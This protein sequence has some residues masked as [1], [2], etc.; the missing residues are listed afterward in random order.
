MSSS[1]QLQTANNNNDEAGVKQQLDSRQQNGNN[2]TNGAAKGNGICPIKS[3]AS[4]DWPREHPRVL[5]PELCNQFYQLGWVS[6]TGGGLSIKQGGVIHCAPSG[7]QKERLRPEDMF[8]LN[9]NYEVIE[10]PRDPK[11][12]ISECLPLFRM[13]FDKR[14][15]GCCIHSH[16]IYANL[17]TA[18]CTQV[19]PDTK[20]HEFRIRKQEMIK[21]LKRCNSGQT[22]QYSD[23]LIVPIIQNTAYERDLVD[24]MYSAEALYPETCAIL[25]KNHG[26]YVW[27]RTW[28]QAKTMAECYEYLFKLKLEAHKFGFKWDQDELII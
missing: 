21:G 11:L 17:V 25:V 23:T 20:L 12:K 6:G 10:H 24:S 7:V 5:I 27:G 28:Q 8:V 16:S 15:A 9:E 4:T 1:P 22:L 19:N 18:L 13:A 2:N 14:N 3:A 26:V